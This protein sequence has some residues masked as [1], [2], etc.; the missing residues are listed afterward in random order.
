LHEEGYEALERGDLAAARAAFTKAL[1][2]APAD[3]VAKAA[4]AQIGLQERLETEAAAAD[5]ADQPGA[6]VDQVMAAADLAVASGQYAV[7][8]GRLLEALRTAA[9]EDKDRLR[10]R[11]LELFEVAGPDEPAVGQARRRL[12]GLLF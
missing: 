10:L 5:G 4:L 11:L 9:P 7:G 8:F 12:A 2:E 6:S 3:A 1:A